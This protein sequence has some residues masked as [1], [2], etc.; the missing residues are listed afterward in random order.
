MYYNESMP[1][2]DYEYEYPPEELSRLREQCLGSFFLA[3]ALTVIGLSVLTSG[4]RTAVWFAA[5]YWAV[6]T[7][8][9]LLGYIAIRR[10][11]SRFPDAR[12]IN[13]YDQKLVPP[14]PKQPEIT[15]SLV[16]P[17]SP[18]L[19]RGEKVFTLI[20]LGVCV[21]ISS[22]G[23]YQWWAHNIFLLPYAFAILVAI[24]MFDYHRWMQRLFAT[25]SR[26]PEIVLDINGA[27]FPVDVLDFSLAKKLGKAGE[28]TLD[29]SW[30]D[31]TD[32]TVTSGIDDPDVYK[33]Q[34][35]NRSF[36][37]EREKFRHREYDILDYARSVGQ[38]TVALRD[39]VQTYAD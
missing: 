25:T 30:R 7:G 33:I 39:K 35:S 31:I 18:R 10:I 1:R 16:I 19:Y 27:H 28:S 14:L 23:A 12:D 32:W 3:A 21:A 13:G 24:P 6:V 9:Y 38:V 36:E 34:T 15:E 22:V 2:S 20:I 11:K 29:I 17:I 4:V 26:K 37:I 8:A 5:L